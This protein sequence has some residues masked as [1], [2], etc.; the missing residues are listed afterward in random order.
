MSQFRIQ[1]VGVM[2]TAKLHAFILT[3]LALIMGI[4]YALFFGISMGVQFGAGAGLLAAAACLI[5]LPIIYGV[6]GFV[7][8]ALMAWIYNIAARKIG[9][10]EIELSETS[11][12]NKTV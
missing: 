2:S 4:I 6:M 3:I 9:G 12:T 8:G 11:I 10:L 7:L 1:K 5:L